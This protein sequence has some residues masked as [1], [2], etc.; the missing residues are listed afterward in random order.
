MR[1]EA[2]VPEWGEPEPLH[3]KDAEAEAQE[4]GMTQRETYRRR[5]RRM[6]SD[7]AALGDAVTVPVAEWIGGRL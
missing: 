4:G 5:A 6:T 3:R 2:E 1:T 7:Y